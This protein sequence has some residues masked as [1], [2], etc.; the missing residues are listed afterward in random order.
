[1]IIHTI[2][3]QI[4]CVIGIEKRAN[5][6]I[7]C[8]N[9][10]QPIRAEDNVVSSSG[11]WDQQRMRRIRSYLVEKHGTMICG[12]LTIATIVDVHWSRKTVNFTAAKSKARL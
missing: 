10:Y 4:K 2:W 12:A 11:R 3:W 8:A 7:F 9:T 5:R 6:F 1:M